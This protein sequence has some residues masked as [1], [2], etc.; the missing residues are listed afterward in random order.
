MRRT[1]PTSAQSRRTRKSA[2]SITTIEEIPG[3]P[4]TGRPFS[5]P[6]IAWPNAGDEPNRNKASSR[7]RMPPIL[8]PYTADST[9]ATAARELETR[10]S[11]ETEYGDVLT[12]PAIAAL[13]HLAHFDRDRKKLMDAR[14]DRRRVRAGQKQSIGFLDPEAFIG[15]TSIKVRDA[16]EGRFVGGE[17]PKD[18]QRQWIQGT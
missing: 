16:R 10:G 14:I 9:M 7:Y 3:S 8:L 5:G 17:I 2:R 15:R 13:E 6:P 4:A 11:L 1:A 18:L 12:R